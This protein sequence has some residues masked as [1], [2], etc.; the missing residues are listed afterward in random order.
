MLF[1]VFSCSLKSCLHLTVSMLT[2]EHCTRD[3][4]RYV[5]ACGD[6]IAF[7]DD[8]NN[9]E[10]GGGAIALIDHIFIHKPSDVSDDT[11]I[12]IVIIPVKV[13]DEKDDVLDLHKVIYETYEPRIIGLNS[14][15]AEK[16]YIVPVEKTGDTV[17]VD[18][19]VQWL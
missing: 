7:R 13:L 9:S 12:F 2:F 3:F 18:W 8:S 19:Q 17:L 11:Y 5:F 10:S 16:L 6:H 14:V 4:R 1:E 15:A